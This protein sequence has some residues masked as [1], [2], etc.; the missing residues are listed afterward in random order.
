MAPRAS[1][2]VRAAVLTSRKSATWV[3]TALLSGSEPVFA[4]GLRGSFLTTVRDS[5]SPRPVPDT[6]PET[7]AVRPSAAALNPAAASDAPLPC[8]AAVAAGPLEARAAPTTVAS[9]PARRKARWAGI[10]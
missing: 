8:S 1:G 6:V 7:G 9:S 3:A 2:P 10:F 5:P 4:M